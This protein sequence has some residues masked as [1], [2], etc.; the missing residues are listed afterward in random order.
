MS[1]AVRNIW[2]DVDARVI[3]AVVIGSV[4][5]LIPNALPVYLVSL[6][7]SRQLTEA[8]AGFCGMADAGGI[9]IGSI[10]CALLPA[11]VKRLNWRRTVLF[12]LII[13]ILANLLTI[14]TASFGELI[15]AR[16]LAGI[17]AGMAVAIVYAFLAEGDAA[18]QLGIFTVAQ[19]GTGWLGVTLL[20]GVTDKYGATGLFSVLSLVGLVALSLAFLMPV[21]SSRRTVAVSPGRASFGRVSGLGWLGVASVALFYTAVVAI[22]A[23]LEYM[24]VAWGVK[25][26]A[27]ASGVANLLF[28]GMVGGGLAAI[29]GSRFGFI[30]PL[31]VGFGGLIL[32]AALFMLLKPLG[33]FLPVAIL[34]GFCFSYVLNYHFEAVVTVD[35][36]SS[37]AMLVNVAA[38]LGFTAGPA[39]GGYLSTPNFGLVNGV[40]MALLVLALIVI[41]FA[42]R[43]SQRKDERTSIPLAIANT[44]VDPK[45][46]A[47]EKRIDAAFA[48]LRQR[49]PFEL[50]HADKF[51]PF[52]VASKHADVLYIEK[53]ADL[54]QNANGS[55]MLLD[56]ASV[57]YSIDTFGE[58]NVTRS[59]VEVDGQEHKDLRAITSARFSPKAMAELEA[60]LRDFA[61]ESIAEMRAKGT[62]CDFAQ[63]VAYVYPLRAV[64]TTLGIP[65][66]DE[67]FMLR[68]A[69][70]LHSV[71]D[72]DLNASG[73]SA[74]SAEAMR[75]IDAGLKDLHDYYEEVTKQL[76]FT[77]NNS[78]NSLIANAKIRG[79]YLT[80]RQ[81]HGYY[82]IT[83]TA[84]HD[85][86]A[87]TIASAMWVLAERPELLKRLQDEPDAITRFVEE[88]IRWATPVKSFMRT[89]TED[90]EVRGKQVKKGDWIMLSYQSA[91]R[92]D[93]VFANP[94]EFNIDRP[95]MPNLTF[96]SGPHVCIGQHLARLEM[97]ILWEE[98]L[99]QLAEVSLDGAPKITLSNFVCGPKSV[100]IRYRWAG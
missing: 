72:P 91:N 9:A 33:G 79:E 15:A 47:D 83:A 18:R 43:R 55:V 19:L 32:S 25:P 28:A 48:E 59:L 76:R 16:I 63:D 80:P 87:F 13:M 50:A 21:M 53:K 45:A 85:T 3:A 95:R 26:E 10:G 30:K 23:Y 7:Q 38:L 49:A 64:M 5:N 4:G 93:E 89:A 96:G 97:K 46:Y 73:S 60:T 90:T 24:G 36:T 54:F 52:W 68:T 41:L 34:F 39:M 51:Q 27:A 98:L 78:I 20:G 82:L 2:R 44:I 40:S 12:G 29:V 81:L 67:A 8:Q 62:R 65:R 6:S 22:Y 71:S 77:P 1:T 70:A 86:T 35:P 57:A 75:M 92:D 84:G 61:R 99:P 94:F 74:A 11:L 100:P 42:L 66:E 37:T 69:H 17:G 14:A 58:P 56:K 31:V 88:T